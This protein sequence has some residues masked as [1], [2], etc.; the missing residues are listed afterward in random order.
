MTFS[1]SKRICQSECKYADFA[2]QCNILLSFVIIYLLCATIS[3]ENL[4]KHKTKQ[5]LMLYSKISCRLWML[6]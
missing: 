3:N 2:F 1:H 4:Y 5:Y 6:N